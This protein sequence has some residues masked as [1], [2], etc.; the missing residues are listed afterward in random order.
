MYRRQRPWWLW[1]LA[2]LGSLAMATRTY[3]LTQQGQI[4]DRH[5]KAIQQLGSEKAEV[6]LGGIYALERITNDSPQDRA[7]IADVLP[8]FV[9]VHAPWPTERPGQ[10]R[11]HKGAGLFQAGCPCGRAAPGLRWHDLRHTCASLLIREGASVKA[12]QRQLGHATASITLDTYGHLYDDVVEALAE[13]LERLRAAAV[14]T[15]ARP[16]DA[17]AVVSLAKGAD[18]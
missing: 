8:A 18:R 15:P 4:T 6:R 16:T 11:S 3:R 14:A 17:P 2:A 12:V 10:P 5:T 9:R 1:A 13:R 7:T